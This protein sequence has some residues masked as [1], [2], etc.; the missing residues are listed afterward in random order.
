[1]IYIDYQDYLKS[2]IIQSYM[3]NSYIWDDLFSQKNSICFGNAEI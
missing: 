2:N 1:M 3:D